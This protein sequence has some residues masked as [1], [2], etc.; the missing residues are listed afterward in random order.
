MY[1]DY[2]GHCKFMADQAMTGNFI[3]AAY[4]NSRP[5]LFRVTCWGRP[6]T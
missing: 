6:L 2:V 1:L 3:D 4:V 5:H